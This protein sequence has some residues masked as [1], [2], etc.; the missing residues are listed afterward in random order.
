VLHE[1][2]TDPDL[3]Q[4]PGFPAKPNLY[5]RG[6]IDW[7]FE[8]HPYHFSLIAGG[9]FQ[10]LDYSPTLLVGLP[11]FHNGDRN[12]NQITGYVSGGYEFSPGYAAFVKVTYDDRT[13]DRKFNRNG[14]EENSSGFSIDAGLDT[15]VTNL[16]TGNVYVGY[17]EQNYPNHEGNVTGVDFGASL[18]WT[19]DELWLVT[20]DASHTVQ[21]TVV[22]TA[23]AEDDSQIK[24]T[25]DWTVRPYLVIEGQGYYLHSDFSQTTRTDNYY[26]FGLSAKY[27]LNEYMAVKAGYNLESRTSNVAILGAKQ[28]FTDNQVSLALLLQE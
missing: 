17:L 26:G 24:V 1:P 23:V 2:R 28:D 21:N 20:V 5:K 10:R 3:L 9:S 11:S 14:V 15:R 22:G 19:P 6:L 4:V 13:F 25:A 16:I 8:Y 27:I 7:A 18:K 12:S